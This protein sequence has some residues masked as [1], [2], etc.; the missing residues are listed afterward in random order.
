MK[1]TIANIWW[2]RHGE[3]TAN[4]THTLSHRV[5]DGDLTSL[6][7]RQA[8][9]LARRLADDGGPPVNYLVS[10]PLRRARQ[11]A[12]IVG[13]GLG[14]PVAAEIEDLREVD[15]GTLDGRSDAQAWDAYT[16][17]LSAWKAGHVEAR[18]PGGEDCAE[19]CARLCRALATVAR[20]CPDGRALIVA[21]GANLRAALP[22][23][24]G[25]PDPGTDLRTGMMAE[26]R[27]DPAAGKGT[28]VRL[29]NWPR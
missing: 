11:T 21:H 8:H 5:F 20:N 25:E 3:N 22:G 24:T 12:R 27:V 29:L 10:S 2:A 28:G 26:L 14:L 16:R 4:L 23:L 18:F 15:V 7:R 1:S 17:V 6:G 9:E 19:L 13:A